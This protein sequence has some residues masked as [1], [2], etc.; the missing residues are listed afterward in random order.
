MT[1]V[2]LD[3]GVL[4][5]DDLIRAAEPFDCEFAIVTVTRREVEDTPFEV[6]LRDFVTVRE[7]AVYGEAR[8]GEAAWASEVSGA[9]LDEILRII[10]SG[11]FPRSRSNLSEGEIHQFRDALILEA[12]IRERRDIFVTDDRRA[13]VRSGKRDEL[14][15]KFGVR[16]MER[17]EFLSECWAG[18]LAAV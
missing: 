18:T 11:G 16:I 9:T 3:T 10:S 1:K 13:F 5:A 15:A 14:S 12:H 4:P 2:T 8:W 7:T 17:G 6:H